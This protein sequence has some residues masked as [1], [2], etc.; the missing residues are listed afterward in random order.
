[1]QHWINI[2]MFVQW[3][4]K[5]ALAQHSGIFNLP[6]KPQPIPKIPIGQTQVAEYQKGHAPEA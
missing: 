4:L 3:W 2:P 5:L 6:M 1:M